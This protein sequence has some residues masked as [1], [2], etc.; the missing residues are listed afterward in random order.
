MTLNSKKS[1][2]A[3]ASIKQMYLEWSLETF[4]VVYSLQ[5]TVK[6]MSGRQAEI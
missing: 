1:A 6:Y 5:L 2:A 3:A 4:I